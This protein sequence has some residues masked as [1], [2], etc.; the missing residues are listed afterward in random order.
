MTNQTTSPSTTIEWSPVAARFF[1]EEYVDTDA[2]TITVTFENIEVAERALERRMESTKELHKKSE[3]GKKETYSNRLNSLK[4]LRKTLKGCE[5]VLKVVASNEAM[6]NLVQHPTGKLMP[7]MNSS[8]RDELTRSMMESGYLTDYPIML[9]EGMILDGW[10]RYQVATELGLTPSFKDFSSSKDGE[11]ADPVGFVI[12]T[13]LA[14]RHL[15]D[16]QRAQVALDVKAAEIDELTKMTSAQAAAALSVSASKVNR[17]QRIKSA[18]STLDHAIKVGL[19]ESA[20]ADKVIKDPELLA[21]VN[22]DDFDVA[23]IEEVA[24]KAKRKPAKEGR[25]RKIFL[26]GDGEDAWTYSATV[27]DA[28]SDEIGEAYVREVPDVDVEDLLESTA[29]ASLSSRGDIRKAVSSLRDA[30]CLAIINEHGDAEAQSL[31][32]DS[33]RKALVDAASRAVASIESDDAEDEDWE[34]VDSDSWLDDI[35]LDFDD[36]DEDEDEDEEDTLFDD[37]EDFE[38]EEDDN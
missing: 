20:T 36:E 9:H 7:P 13:N 33:G 10:H 11:D 4:E 27:Y 17:A 34:D 19:I 31:T 8:D 28:D 24:N 32:T 5:K 15:T 1:K 18:S 21:E 14:R 2:R 23:D 6:S 25:D 29:L 38:D 30:E 22:A 37:P 12:A 35:D 3:G 16:D 26:A